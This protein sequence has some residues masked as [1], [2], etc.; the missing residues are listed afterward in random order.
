MP[1]ADDVVLAVLDIDGHLIAEIGG[2][3][4]FAGKPPAAGPLSQW[5]HEQA[6]KMPDAK[7][8][9]DEALAQAKRENKRV[10]LRKRPRGGGPRVPSLLPPGPLSRA[11]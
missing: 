11:I 9:Y 3:Q 8:L 1:T 7:K 6:P 5:L 4:L 10:L 2:Q